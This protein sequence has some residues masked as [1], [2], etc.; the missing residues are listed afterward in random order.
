MRTSL[1]ALLPLPLAAA[2]FTAGVAK[3]DL[4]PP[5]G[6]PMSGYQIRYAKGKRDPI[7]ARV[8]AISD[9]TRRVAIVTLDLCFPFEPPAMEE[10]RAAVRPAI[11]EVIFHASHTHSGPT[12]TLAPGALKEA[13]PRVV[14]ALKQAASNL[15]PARIGTGWGQT[16]IG[17]NRRYIRHDGSVQ[18]FWR[19]EPKMTSTFPVDPT[20]GVIRVDRDGGTPLA[21]LVH[22]ACH[23]VI[24][25]PDNLDYSADFPYEMRRGIEEATP[26]A[27]AFFLQGAPGDINPYYDKTPLIEDAAN[28][29]RET[30]RKLAAEAVRVARTIRTQPVTAIKSKTVIVPARNRWNIEKLKAVAAERYR[31]DVTRSAR[32]LRDDMELPVTTLLLD[33]S[34]AFAGMPGEPF[35]EFQ[36]QLRAKSPV[37]ASF[38]LGYTNG[39]FAYF[40]TIAAATRGGYGANTTVNPTEVGSGER[41]L[42]TALISIYE[43]LG[44]LKPAPA[45]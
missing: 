6:L 19:N 22:Y 31:L 7:E 25:G 9:G 30:G 5:L 37:P 27:M 33:D 29:M 38:L 44:K 39:Y 32:L 42:N 8:L 41:M 24:F 14:G 15:A 23:P 26:G 17:F 3:V 28:V 18:M 2:T 4:D 45:Q 10:I 36:M 16:Y 43:L 20:V 13:I 11:D 40:P 34:I 1:L 12:Y 21:V 35:V